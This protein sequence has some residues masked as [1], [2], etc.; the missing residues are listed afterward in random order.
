MFLTK[1][2]NMRLGMFPEPKLCA[3]GCA[4]SS[5]ETFQGLPGRRCRLVLLGAR[6]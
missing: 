4:V 2:V 3:I 1:M 6:T 5:G